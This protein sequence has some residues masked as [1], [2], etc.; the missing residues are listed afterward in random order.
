MSTQALLSYARE[1]NIPR[2][3]AIADAMIAGLRV[4]SYTTP[5]GAAIEPSVDHDATTL[6]ELDE[7]LAADPGLI[8]VVID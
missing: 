6:D 7:R 5:I 2:G 3:D 8:Y 4:G 1:N